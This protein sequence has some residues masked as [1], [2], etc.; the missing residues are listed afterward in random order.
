MS[1]R[2]LLPRGGLTG[3]EKMELLSSIAIFQDLSPEQMESLD[4]STRTITV[5]KGRVVFE[6]DTTGEGLFL[7]KSGKAQLYRLSPEGKKFIL[8]TVG[9]GRFLAR[10]RSSVRECTARLRNA[11]SRRLSVL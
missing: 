7:L 8:D 11:S 5:D 1:I 9:R 10:W 6:P 4:S 3:P 2:P